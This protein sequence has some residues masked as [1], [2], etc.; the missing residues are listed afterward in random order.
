MATSNSSP[1]VVLAPRAAGHRDLLPASGRRGSRPC[2]RPRAV[3]AC[4]R[5]ASVALVV[6]LAGLSPRPAWAET[7]NHAAA[8]G[9][10]A[11]GISPRNAAAGVAYVGS[12]VC[13]RCHESIYKRFMETNMGRSMRL[14]S[15]SAELQRLSAPITVYA[16]AYGEYVQLFRQGSGW[17]QSIYKLD[18][19]G[20]QVF[21]DTKEIAFVIGSGINGVGFVAQRGDSL[22]EAPLSYYTKAGRWDLSP[23]FQHGFQPNFN[24]PLVKEC[25]ACH[26]GRERPAAGAPGRY[27]NPP[28]DELAIGCENCH[29][30]GQL[31]VEERRKRILLPGVIDTSIVNPARLSTWRATNM[32]MYCHQGGDAEV[33]QPGRNYMDFRPGTSLNKVV[34]IFQIP[35]GKANPPRT[36]PFINRY[37]DL[38]LSKCFMA[39][40]G[41]LT[42][43]TCHDPHH[44]PPAQEVVSYFRKKCFRCHTDS[45]CRLPL[46]KRLQ[47][48]PSDD[49]TNCHMRKLPGTARIPHSSLTS[50]R[51]TALPDEPYPAEYRTTPELPDLV[52]VDADPSKAHAI[53]PRLTLFAAYRI[54]AEKFPGDAYYVG[55]YRRILDEVSA[56]EPDNPIV[57]SALA[58]SALK[59]GKAG[60]VNTA[61]TYLSRAIQKGS[62]SWFDYLLLGDLLTRAD[63]VSQ[64]LTVLHQGSRLAPYNVSFYELLTVLYMKTGKYGEAATTA[65]EGLRLSPESALLRDLLKKIEAALI[66]P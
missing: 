54:L 36:P 49:C 27:Q 64:A 31:H 51:I 35:L 60:S 1:S 25:L 3:P 12:K 58:E 38:S 22:F 52:D 55:R 33:W 11:G 66:L 15:E 4:L 24:R 42:C 56:T 40:G 20:K 61:I 21:T 62:T 37:G 23:T 28:F 13:A 16:T 43:I 9:A 2:R 32:C 50:H 17:F 18:P 39:S 48:N 44:E 6:V 14:P 59:D 46:A 34:A 53:V 65:R 47:G 57:L 7:S 8:G 5:R 29:G 30:P 41:R 45:S 26:S 19:R 10:H 63:R